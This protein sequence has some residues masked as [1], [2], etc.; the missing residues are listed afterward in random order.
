MIYIADS[1]LFIT[2]KRIEGII[3]TVPSVLDE[4]RDERSRTIMELM[5]VRIEPVLQS[6][7]REVT[8]KAKETKDSEELSRTDLDL[9]AKAL[10][11]TRSENTILVTD[12]YAVQNT[13][14]QLGI[15]VIPAGQKKIKDILLW[16]K[17][18]IGCKRRFPAGDDCPVCGT[19]LKKM[20]KK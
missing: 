20:R 7:I 2:R 5:N 8:S 6:F 11:Y 14:I 9:L 4:I 1:S 12:D 3:I 15:K 19:P 18:C 17:F 16:E 13:A 10:E